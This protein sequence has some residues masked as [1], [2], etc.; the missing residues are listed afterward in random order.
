MGSRSGWEGA[1][2]WGWGRCG[3]GGGGAVEVLGAAPVTPPPSQRDGDGGRRGPGTG[4]GVGALWLWLTWTARLPALPTRAL[5]RRPPPRASPPL[6]SWTP[7]L[8]LLSL[9]LFCFFSF[10]CALPPLG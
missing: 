9:F 10:S 8:S 4:G 5:C 6:R 3:T 2:W 7:L 1:R